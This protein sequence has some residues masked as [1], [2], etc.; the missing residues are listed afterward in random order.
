MDEFSFTIGTFLRKRLQAMTY[1]DPAVPAEDIDRWVYLVQQMVCPVSRRLDGPD[2]L[3]LFEE[4]FKGDGDFKIENVKKRKRD[5]EERKEE[6]KEEK[7]VEEEEELDKDDEE[8]EMDED[9]M[10]ENEE[11][12]DVDD[13][14]EEYDRFDARNLADDDNVSSDTELKTS[15]FFGL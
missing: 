4:L 3:D 6:K 1:D 2:L 10:D 14:D 12:E 15:N 5:S 13:D 7:V 11:A 9:N 8:D